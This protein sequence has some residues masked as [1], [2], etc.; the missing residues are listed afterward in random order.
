MA[1]EFDVQLDLTRVNRASRHVALLWA[2][3]AIGAAIAAFILFSLLQFG[4]PW[5]AIAGACGAIFLGFF[6][7]LVVSRRASRVNTRW[8]ALSG[9]T[10]HIRATE[11]TLEVQHAAAGMSIRWHALGPIVKLRNDWLLLTYSQQNYIPLPLEQVPEDALLFIE[12]E[13]VAHGGE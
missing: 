8:I 2:R 4:W 9:G 10:L 3:R 5:G 11:E 12:A 13:V 6:A 7:F 1:H